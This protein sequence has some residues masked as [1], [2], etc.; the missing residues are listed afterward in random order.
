[1]VFVG[2]GFRFN[3]YNPAGMDQGI[4][5]HEIFLYVVAWP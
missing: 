3:G 5:Y 2:Y 1:M 4:D